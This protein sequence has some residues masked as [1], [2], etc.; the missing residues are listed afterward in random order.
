MQALIWRPSYGGFHIEALM[1]MLTFGDPHAE[2][3]MRRAPHV[4]SHMEALIW[5]PDVDAL[6]VRIPYGGS[7]KGIPSGGSHMEALIWRLPHGWH[8]MG[9]LSYGGPHV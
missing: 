9:R 8:H 4:G 6:E 3:P 7:H 2:A 1:W 5:R